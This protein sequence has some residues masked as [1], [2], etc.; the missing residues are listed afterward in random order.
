[1]STVKKLSEE[2]ACGL[3]E[4]LPNLTKPVIR[5]LSLATAAMLEAQ[6]PN[7]VELSN[8]LPLDLERQDMR[9]QWLR[10][11][12][13]SP[14]LRCEDV[15]APFARDS[16]Q[17]AM[18]HGQ[19][20]LLSMDQ[21]DLGDRMAILM[22]TVRVGGRALPLIW[23]AETGAAN[24]G[25]AKQKQLLEQVLTWI[26]AGAKVML[27]TDRF[28]PSVDLFNWLDDHTW[29][30]RLRLKG[31]L[32]VDPGVGDETTTSQL[33]LPGMTERYLPNV[34]L[35]GKEPVMTNIGIL[36]EAGHDESWIIAMN[37]TPT[38]AAVLDYGSRW[39]IEPTFSDFKSR[40]FE[41]E[42][43][44]L[45]HADRIERLILLMALAMHWCVRIGQDNAV[46]CP[47]PL[48]KKRKNN[49]SRRIGVSKNLT[50]ASFHGS[51]AACAI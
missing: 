34:R 43:S 10:R 7:T 15:I 31:N 11:L 46:Q 21:T 27:L 3:K 25:F 8:M 16:L 17:Q 9:E 51:L 35:F 23:T 41:L 38:R 47:T 39:A 36:H 50:V 28:Y 2:I 18:E 5:K 6:T 40:G 45:K 19:T 14:A 42:D 4:L 26:P 48:E 24:I 12:L 44:Q 32:L 29:Q 33:L 22:L 37:C 20:I 49:V 13:T 30:Y 1:M